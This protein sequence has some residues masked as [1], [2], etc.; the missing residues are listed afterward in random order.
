MTQPTL[1]REGITVALF[2]LLAALPGLNTTSRRLA[3]WSDV[4]PEEQPALF[5]S[6]GNQAQEQDPDGLPCRW[7]MAFSVHLY[8]YST[9][10]TVAPSTGINV[11]LD[12]LEAALAPIHAGAPGWPGSVQVLGD[13]TG[14]IRHAW[15][16]GP[17]ETDEGVLGPQAVAIIPIE[18]EFHR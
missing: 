14:R 6:A 2:N 1:T 18:V 13:T 4:P 16:S 15:I 3:H 10:P 11:L 12:A 5:L 9:D 17:V 7:R 8:N